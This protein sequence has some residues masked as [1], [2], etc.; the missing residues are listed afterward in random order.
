MARRLMNLNERD[1][2]TLAEPAERERGVRKGRR[3]MRNNNSK[4][5]S[6]CDERADRA[7]ADIQELLWRKRKWDAQFSSRLPPPSTTAQ[8]QQQFFRSNEMMNKQR[9]RRMK[10]KKAIDGEENE[11][12]IDFLVSRTLTWLLF[13]SGWRP[14]SELEETWSRERE[15][16]KKSI[17]RIY[18]KI[19]K[20]KRG[21][22]TS[23]VEMMM[24]REIRVKIKTCRRDEKRRE[25]KNRKTRKRSREI[26]N[27]LLTQR[28]SLYFSINNIF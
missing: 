17:R 20:K 10:H 1:A 5:S 9:A 18:N 26:D 25:G 15:N 28:A 12:L 21:G 22:N 23:S 8:R 4:E 3:K 11:N 19:E 2:V 16:R 7:R 24:C 6:T 14:E 13:N 27:N